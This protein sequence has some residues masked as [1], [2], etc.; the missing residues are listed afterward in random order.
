MALI[1]TSRSFSPVI[2]DILIS[3]IYVEKSADCVTD[4]SASS[5]NLTDNVLNRSY[6][7]SLQPKIL[8]LVVPATFWPH[9]KKLK[10]WNAIQK[11]QSNIKHFKPPSFDLYLVSR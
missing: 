3:L 4:S 1:Y 8:S 11:P 9:L 2:A 5:S 7:L 6:N 10:C